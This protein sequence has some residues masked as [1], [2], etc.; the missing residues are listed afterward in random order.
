VEAQHAPDEKMKV[1]SPDVMARGKVW[2]F[3]S[4][5]LNWETRGAVARAME[6]RMFLHGLG[7]GIGTRL[8]R[9]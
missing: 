9:F 7:Q 5:G 8:G 3:S 1:G 4:Y 2:P 6:F